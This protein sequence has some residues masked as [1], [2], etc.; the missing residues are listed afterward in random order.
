MFDEFDLVIS[1][2][3]IANANEKKL[4]ILPSILIHKDMNKF[5]S[6]L[7]KIYEEH[8]RELLTRREE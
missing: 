1:T 3:P 5:T 7:N 2:E 6:L 8:N 4:V